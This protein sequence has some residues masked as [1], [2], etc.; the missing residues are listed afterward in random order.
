MSESA[1]FIPVL[2]E[3]K[4]ATAAPLSSHVPAK[5]VSGIGTYLKPSRNHSIC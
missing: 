5:G 1:P 4:I 2:L 3:V